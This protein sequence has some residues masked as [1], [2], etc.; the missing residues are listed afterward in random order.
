M[1]N[2]YLEIEGL[3]SQKEVA[4]QE[5]N[6]ISNEPDVANE[7]ESYGAE[8]EKDQDEEYGPATEDLEKTDDNNTVDE[9][10]ADDVLTDNQND[11]FNWKAVAGVAG[12]AAVVGAGIYL[13]VRKPWKVAKVFYHFIEIV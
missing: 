3:K 5:K 9:D 6:E 8:V 13:A 1:D 11:D 7:M 10:D 4:E 12:V 2:N